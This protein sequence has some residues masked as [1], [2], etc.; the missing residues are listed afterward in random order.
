MTPH[1]LQD[2]RIARPFLAVAMI[3]VALLGLPPEGSHAAFPG[4]NGKIAYAVGGAAALRGDG[5]AVVARDPDGGGR[6]V[7]AR[8]CVGSPAYSPDGRMAALQGSTSPSEATCGALATVH[9]DGSA[10]TALP[11]LMQPEGDGASF[12]AS[13]SEPAWSPRGDRLVFTG[14]VGYDDGFQSSR[15][16]GVYVVRPDGTSLRRLPP[17]DA[18]EPQWSS[19]GL[20]AFSRWPR[21]GDPSIWVVRPDGSGLRRV[22]L[23]GQQPAWSPDG[24]RLAFETGR[25]GGA[26]WYGGVG[27][28][29][30]IVNV[31]GKGRHGVARGYDPVWSP[32]GKRLALVRERRLRTGLRFQN[33]VYTV[34]LDGRNPRLVARRRGGWI[35]NRGIGG[36]DWQPLQ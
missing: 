22:A 35:S 32:D 4:R 17:S 5:T 26:P 18:S 13:D 3:L 14:T 11:R 16:S 19:R 20:I 34:G 23:R 30:A 36:L 31:D 2:P 8:G 27:G 9:A 21:H 29:I 24:R 33:S 28:R 6:T 1:G 15:D 12:F 25:R 10:F 7:L